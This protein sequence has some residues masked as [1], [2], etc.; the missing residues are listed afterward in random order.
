VARDAVL[1]RGFAGVARAVLSTVPRGDD[2]R[3]VL[4]LDLRG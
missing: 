1:T 2:D 3:A 4:V